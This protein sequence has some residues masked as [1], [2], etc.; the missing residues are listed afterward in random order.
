MENVKVINVDDIVNQK[1]VSQGNSKTPNFLDSLIN[2]PI[3]LLRIGGILIIIGAI[4]G[5]I[6]N[7]QSDTSEETQ[8]YS[9][10][11]LPIINPDFGT[12]YSGGGGIDTLYDDLGGNDPLKE[13]KLDANINI[14]TEKYSCKFKVTYEGEDKKMVECLSG[15]YNGDENSKFCESYIYNDKI[16]GG[17]SLETLYDD[18]GGNDYA[19]VSG[20]YLA[21]INISAG[22][23]FD[24]EN[25]MSCSFMVE[26]EGKNKRKVKCNNT[27]CPDKCKTY[28]YFNRN[29]HGENG[30]TLL[31]NT[32]ISR[33]E[34]SKDEPCQYCNDNQK[35]VDD[36]CVC[37]DGY[38]GEYCQNK[39][40]DS[41][42][43]TSKGISSNNS[44][45]IVFSIFYVL[46][47]S[48][49]I[50]IAVK[51]GPNSKF[52]LPI[53]FM[54]GIYSIIWGYASND[55]YWLI[56]LWMV[57]IIVAIASIINL[58]RNGGTWVGILEFIFIVF[59]IVNFFIMN[60]L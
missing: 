27:D 22:Y 36:E 53:L 13:G 25:D 14:D 17:K 54:F 33:R 37:I 51:S 55:W 19:R 15:C 50:F 6:I 7:S 44:N 35:C 11:N 12:N 32:Y 41:P 42:D 23:D 43:E 28:E 4:I 29:T 47:L 1:I 57:T 49:I 26:Y 24:K 3:Y 59:Y 20:Q 38:S 45:L 21:N 30:D 52:I 31:D 40:P 8:D 46:L 10:E 34:D 18:A 48:L 9:N 60:R 5:L 39:S 56:L 2:N 58:V 16:D